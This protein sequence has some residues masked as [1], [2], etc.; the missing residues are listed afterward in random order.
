MLSIKKKLKIYKK[1]IKKLE[2]LHTKAWNEKHT[3][4]TFEDKQ[5]AIDEM[6]RI[7]FRMLSIEKTIDDLEWELAMEELV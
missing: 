5:A 2:L 7:N 4:V 1:T 6:D 3:A